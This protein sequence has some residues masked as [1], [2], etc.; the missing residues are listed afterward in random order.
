MYSNKM[1]KNI[2][3]VDT[4]SSHNFIRHIGHNCYIE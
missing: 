4:E 2:G 3:T 1:Y